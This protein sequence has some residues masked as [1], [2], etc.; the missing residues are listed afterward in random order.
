[1][2]PKIDYSDEA[3]KALMQ[4]PEYIEYFE[5]LAW[6]EVPFEEQL[7]IARKLWLCEKVGHAFDYL[8]DGVYSCCHCGLLK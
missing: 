4:S 5:E 2:K 3:V 8:G 6:G 7:E 1:M